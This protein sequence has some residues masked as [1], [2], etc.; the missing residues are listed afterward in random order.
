M[1]WSLIFEYINPE[2]IVVV[3][4]CWIIGYVFKQTPLIPNWSIPYLV[5]AIAIVFVCLIQGFTVQA[6][7]QG[8]LCGAVAVYGNQLVKQGMKGVDTNAKQE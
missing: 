2:L 4:A 5:G 8:I 6:V 3:I 1:E 7:I